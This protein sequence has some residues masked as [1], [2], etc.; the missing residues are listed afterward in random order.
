[1]PD[2]YLTKSQ[3]YYDLNWNVE[4]LPDGSLFDI[5]N[6][7]SKIKNNYLFYEAEIRDLSIPKE[8][9]VVEK[10]NVKSQISKILTQVGLNQKESDDFLAYW[11]PRLDSKPYYFVTLVPLDELNR[12]ETLLFSQ[13]PDTLIRVRMIFEGLDKPVVVSPLLMPTKPQRKG[14]TVVDWG[15]GEIGGNCEGGVVDSINIR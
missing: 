9:W 8:G 11:V 13:K 1:V 15:G 10:A 2:G 5:K 6:Q 14:F 3:P 7:K 12:K 4:A